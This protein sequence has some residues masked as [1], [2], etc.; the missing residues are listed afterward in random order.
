MSVGHGNDLPCVRFGGR[1][2]KL[3]NITLPTGDVIPVDYRMKTG[4]E[5][6]ITIRKVL[7]YPSA[8]F[9]DMGQQGIAAVRRSRK[10]LL[11]DLIQKIIA[12]LAKP[13][14]RYY[15]LLPTPMAHSGHVIPEI[16]STPPIAQAVSD[17]IITQ[18]S[19]GITDILQLQEHIKNFVNINFTTDITDT[20]FF[21]T[22]FDIFRH[23]YWLYNMGQVI[24]QESALKA[25]IGGLTGMDQSP[26][27]S[28][29]VSPAT[30][31]TMTKLP[32]T[33]SNSAET[34]NCTNVY[35]IIMDDGS[36]ADGAATLEH[37]SESQIQTSTAREMD[38]NH[39]SGA[40]N[41]QQQQ[42][43]HHETSESPIY[44]Q[45]QLGVSNMGS[46]VTV[47]SSPQ[48]V[49]QLVKRGLVQGT[50]SNVALTVAKHNP[51]PTRTITT[52]EV[53]Q[54]S[55]IASI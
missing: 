39:H 11:D 32:V 45:V 10:Q 50:I 47:A 21:P 52:I 35:S 26:L 14:E 20:T 2:K 27:T 25:T 12:G 44:S 15:F 40:M 7:R 1:R 28:A 23:V 9:T 37:L 4:C 17:E 51:L 46:Q 8:E 3:D 18:L 36:N 54:R 5:A 22:E 34:L 43:Q 55:V 29:M 24:D 13:S 41:Q 16:E 53:K 49:S 38:L 31:N 6:K 19:N 48:P 42:Q 30:T 33:T